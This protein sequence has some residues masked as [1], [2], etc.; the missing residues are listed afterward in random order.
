M[1]AE[2]ATHIYERRWWI[3]AATV[4][5]SLMAPIDGS[6]L[7]IAISPIQHDFHVVLGQVAWVSLVYLLVIAGLLLPLGRLGDLYGFRRLFLLGVGIFTVASAACGFAPSLGWLITGRIVQGIGACLIMALSPG[8]TTAIFPSRERGRALGLMGM[9]I[10]IGL[11]M[12]PTLAGFL[13]DWQSWRWIFFINLPIGLLGGLWCAR[14]LPELPLA[15]RRRIDW[16]GAALAVTMLA[17]FLLVITQGATWGW[18]TPITIILLAMALLS[19]VAFFTVELRHPAPMLDLSLFKNKVFTG[20]NLAAMMNFLGQFCAVFLTPLLLQRGLGFR[21]EKAGLIM[22]TLP[23]AVLVLAP[24]S[25]ALSDKFGTRMLAVIGESLVAIGLLVLA[26]VIASGQLLHIIPALLLVGVGTGLFQA[27]NNSAIMGSVPRTHLGIGGG[28][29]ATMRNLGM[30][31]GIAISSAVAVAGEHR[32][33]LIHPGAVAPA[34]I[35]GIRLGYV[36]GAA[37]AFLGTLTS[38]I[39]QDHPRHN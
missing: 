24:V 21:A 27:P 9:G 3:L 4:G 33:L 19:G 28:V 13:I 5:V 25:G 37:F 12:G 7:N 16:I 1:S 30:A 11:V 35:H 31:F 38:A 18:L 32:Y 14:M 22:G 34:L 20:A 6:A 36:V 2:V 23:M 29:M 8:I 15:E 26:A 39:R 17:S 10:A